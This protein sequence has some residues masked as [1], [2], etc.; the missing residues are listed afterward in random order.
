MSS[1]V[2]Q[3]RPIAVTSINP[4]CLCEVIRETSAKRGATG[5]RK[6]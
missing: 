1:A 3:N 4:W 5:N 2:T 6:H